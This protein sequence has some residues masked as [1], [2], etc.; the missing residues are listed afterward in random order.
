MVE[1]GHTFGLATSLFG[2][3]NPWLYGN[4]LPPDGPVS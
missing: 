3:P 1:S 4:V 2:C